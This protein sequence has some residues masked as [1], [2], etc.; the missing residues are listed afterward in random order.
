MTRID[1]GLMSNM[2]RLDVLIYSNKEKRKEI[3]YAATR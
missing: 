3:F 2:S 1:N